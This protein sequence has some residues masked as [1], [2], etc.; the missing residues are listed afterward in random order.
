MPK[1]SSSRRRVTAHEDILPF[2]DTTFDEPV[3]AKERDTFPTIIAGATA[4]KFAPHGLRSASAVAEE[5]KR[6]RP[7]LIA[8]RFKPDCPACQENANDAIRHAT[9]T[10][11]QLLSS[12]PSFIG[13]WE[14]GAKRWRLSGQ[15]IATKVRPHKRKSQQ[16]SPEPLQETQATQDDPH[17]ETPGQ[18]SGRAVRSFVAHNATPPLVQLQDALA[19]QATAPTHEPQIEDRMALPNHSTAPYFTSHTLP[20]CLS[21]SL[22]SLFQ[23]PR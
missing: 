16:V 9:T 12:S 7:W 19:A 5:I 17:V 22:L 2:S 13:T 18:S 10:I 4:L 14:R 21:R 15:P 8:R 6:H 11:E 23:T 20:P 1:L 3:T